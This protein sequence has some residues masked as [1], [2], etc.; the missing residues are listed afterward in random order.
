MVRAG[1][2]RVYVLTLL[3]TL[4][5]LQAVRVLYLASRG[6]WRLWG[7]Q[8]PASPLPSALSPCLTPCS[9]WAMP[10]RKPLLSLEHVL[11]RA[12]PPG[13]LRE[14][15]VPVLPC[16]PTRLM[17]LDGTVWTARLSPQAQ[18]VRAGLPGAAVHPPRGEEA[19]E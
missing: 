12:T 8:M 6:A 16:V 2:P 9:P 4:S 11:A 3:R 15:S 7:H 17:L 5:S 19:G 14:P 1:C 13:C 18:G 10:Q